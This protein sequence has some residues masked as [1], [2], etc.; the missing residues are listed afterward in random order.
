MKNIFLI[1]FTLIT[2]VSSLT[3]LKFVE[4]NK[5]DSDASNLNV[6]CASWGLDK[7]ELRACNDGDVCPIPKELGEKTY[8]ISK[9]KY[10]NLYPGEHC[11]SS[12]QCMA[13]GDCKKEF[14]R[15]KSREGCKAH[16]NCDTESYCYEN[17]C[18]K[19]GGLGKSCSTSKRC[20]SNAFCYVCRNYKS[21]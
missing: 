2:T 1:T 16:I 15:L 10:R 14:C 12:N 9:S 20:Q 6:P 11:S 4:M 18:V 13:G 7:V 17:S 3:C 8:C 5:Y 19:A 21:V